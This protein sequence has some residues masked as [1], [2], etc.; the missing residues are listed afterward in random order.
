MSD[1]GTQV[2]PFPHHTPQ[3]SLRASVVREWSHP[4]GTHSPLTHT[5]RL[6][7]TEESWREWEGSGSEVKRQGAPSGRGVMTV[8]RTSSG[9]PRQWWLHWSRPRLDMYSV[10]ERGGGGGGGERERVCACLRLNEGGGDIVNLHSAV[11]VVTMCKL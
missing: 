1:T 5:P 2:L 6:S 11:V 3:A 7:G 10:A 9:M 8:K 4:T